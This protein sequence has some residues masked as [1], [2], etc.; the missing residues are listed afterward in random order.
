MEYI[1]HNNEL[2][3]VNMEP[4][5]KSESKRWLSPKKLT[6]LF[7]GS[8]SLTAV[9]VKAFGAQDLDSDMTGSPLEI[10]VD[11]TPDS[12]SPEE[13]NQPAPTLQDIFGDICSPMG[14][15]SC[16][17]YNIYDSEGNVVNRVIANN[18]WSPEYIASISGGSDSGSAEKIR[19][20][21]PVE[22]P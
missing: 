3:T 12:T 13:P 1:N 16:G 8:L 22:T 5:H 2:S 17:E 15:G 19:D 11:T 18:D 9:G 7:V 14:W 4:S 20:I 21:N 6:A 10:T